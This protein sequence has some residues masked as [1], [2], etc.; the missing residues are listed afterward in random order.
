MITLT[1][2]SI[3]TIQYLS[4]ASVIGSDVTDTL[5][6]QNVK[7]DFSTGA[8]YATI[9]RGTVVNGVFTSNYPS[10]S[11]TVNPDGSFISSDG[12]WTGSLGAS[13]TTLVAQLKSTFDQFIL[14]TGLIQGT[15][16]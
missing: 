13:A 5:Y 9:A 15:S 6:V 4:G 7:L 1:G 10:V 2:T 16:K 3:T 12:K 14:G 8:M 11:V